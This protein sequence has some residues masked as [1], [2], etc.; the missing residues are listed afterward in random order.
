MTD[1]ITLRRL[2]PEFCLEKE[3]DLF[4]QTEGDGRGSAWQYLDQCRQLFACL[5]VNRN[6]QQFR[7]IYID[8][9]YALERLVL[10]QDLQ[11]CSAL[12]SLC[13]FL[14]DLPVQLP[15]PRQLSSGFAP[16]ESGNHWNYVKLPFFP[17]HAET[18]LYWALIGHLFRDSNFLIAASKLADWELNLLDHQYYPFTGILCQENDVALDRFFISRYLLFRA[19]SSFSGR[20][21]LNYAA[22]MQLVHLQN[23]SQKKICLPEFALD[24]WLD[25]N[26]TDA[27][28]EIEKPLSSSIFDLSNGLAGFRSPKECLISTLTGNGTG[29]GAFYREDVRMVS[30]GPHQLPL[31]DCQGFGISQANHPVFQGE[32]DEKKFFIQGTVKA[33]ASRKVDEALALY[34]EGKESSDWLEIKQTFDNGNLKIQTYFLNPSAIETVSFVFFVKGA[35]CK[36]NQKEEIRPCSLKG[37]S[38]PVQP[39]QINGQKSQLLFLG[40]DNCPEMQVIPLA[41]GDNFWG[42]DFLIAYFLKKNICHYSWQI[43]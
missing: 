34:R 32:A 11:L 22:S 7:Q 17:F 26:G 19:A 25:A 2:F 43:S 23:L 41:G 37:F 42:A 9:L 16:I 35:L 4:H 30:C 27:K 10:W 40:D 5:L 3:L 12:K 18:G 29:I 20:L 31:G 36:I 13:R 38:G 6:K 28:S 39:I 21:D 1:K 8:K 33:G 15:N 24:S 14:L